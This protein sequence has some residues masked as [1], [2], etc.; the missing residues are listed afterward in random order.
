MMAL[1]RFRQFIYLALGM[2]L[3]ACG[4]QSYLVPAKFID[5]GATGI[6]MLT[7][8][9]TQSPLA[10]WLLLVN[11]P[12]VVLGYYRQGRGF[13]WRSALA[14]T[15]HALLVTFVPFPV[16]TS[17]KLL[18]A[19]FG[20]VFIGAGVGL[21]MRGGAV[22]DGTD[23]LA[24]LLSKRFP[25]TVGEIVLGMNACLFVVAAN[26]LG[27]EAALYSA[28]TYFAGAKTIDFVLHGIE[29]YT[30]VLVFSNRHD[31]IRKS[32]LEE[33]GRG[34]TIFHGTGGYTQNVQVILFCV[35]T[36]LEIMK[37]ETI[38]NQ[39]DETAFIIELP[40]H[41]VSGGMVKQRAFP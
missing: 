22:L 32:I 20:G 10:L 19:A 9:L 17:D 28:L 25:A 18:A 13:A 4:I 38:V 11:S 24:V 26:F 41:E 7:G 12:F 2:L 6:A 31:E 34:V 35:V 16:I 40:V 23:V 33:L 27:V 29:A 39:V 30:G 3:S 1:L 21:T 5:G 15:G 14:I 37:L 36:R 8:E